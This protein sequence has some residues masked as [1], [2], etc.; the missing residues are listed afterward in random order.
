MRIWAALFWCIA[1]PL[2]AQESPAQSAQAAAARLDIAGA[3]LQAADSKRDRVA[4]LTE[5][6]HAYEAGLVAMRDGLR[7]AAVRQARI[8]AQLQSKRVEVG[9]LLG[10]LQSIGRAPAPLL[11][12]HPSGPLGTARSGMMAADVTPA[13]QAEVEQL[14]AQLEELATLRTLQ[15]SAVDTIAAGLDGAQEARALLSA[16]ISDRTDLP[17]RFV[18][19]PVQTSLLLASAETLDAFA[20]SLTDTFLTDATPISASAEGNLPLPVQGTI[21]RSYNAADAAGIARPGIIIAARPRAMVTTPLPATI[22]FRGP[23][24]DYGN[25]VIL[26]PAADVLFIIAGLAEVFGEPGQV[27]PA[28]SAIGLLGGEQPNV[29]A[30]LTQSDG[31]GGGNATQTLYLEVRDGQS[32]VDPASWFA[33]E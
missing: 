26:E 29:D 24:L 15:E 16:A 9:R 8:E 13:L 20:S 25:V 28:G 7:K 23:L 11:L 33:L 18:D 3:L 12:L 22:L 1:T 32:P 27:L 5:T 17:Q 6:V 2:W 21:L 19:D 30:I 14:R 10:A 31:A 4:A